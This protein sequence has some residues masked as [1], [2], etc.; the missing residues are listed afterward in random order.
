MNRKSAVFWGMTLGSILGGY[1]PALWGG[2]AFS[3]SAIVWSGIG[4]ILG[5]WLGFRMSGE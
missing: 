3:M 5:I 1:I 2:D 4:G